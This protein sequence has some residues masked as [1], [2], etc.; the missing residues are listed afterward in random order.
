MCE[1]TIVG[2]RQAPAGTKI[3][4][5]YPSLSAAMSSGIQSELSATA[6]INEFALKEPPAGWRLDAGHLARPGNAHLPAYISCVPALK[7]TFFFSFYWQQTHTKD[8]NDER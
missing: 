3:W 2:Q 6:A 8:G 1:Q 4:L 7:A 5:R